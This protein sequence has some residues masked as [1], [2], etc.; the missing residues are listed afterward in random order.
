MW[1]TQ[2]LGYESC[3]VIFHVELQTT[4]I[5]FE[6]DK[7]KQRSLTDSIEPRMTIPIVNM[8]LHNARHFIL[9]PTSI[10]T[11]NQRLQR[12]TTPIFIIASSFSLITNGNHDTAP[13]TSRQKQNKLDKSLLTDDSSPPGYFDGYKTQFS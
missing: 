1:K 2:P 4:K 6:D 10:I 12:R 11:T 13:H 3:K 7:H 8:C 9:K 5:P